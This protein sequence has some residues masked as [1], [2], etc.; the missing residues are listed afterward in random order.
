MW[1]II[2]SL[3]ESLR[4]DR[5]GFVA[6]L[7]EHPES[8]NPYERTCIVL[9][10]STGPMDFVDTE[11]Y[12][13]IIRMFSEEGSIP[14]WLSSGDNKTVVYPDPKLQDAIMRPYGTPHKHLIREAM[15]LR[16]LWKI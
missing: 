4:P 16:E 9:R 13:N 11:A 15:R 1:R 8:G 14:V 12:L 3:P 7:E 10:S 5:C 6:S 2:D